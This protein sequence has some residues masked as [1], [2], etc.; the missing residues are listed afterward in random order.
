MAG[1]ELALLLTQRFKE[2]FSYL[3][4]LHV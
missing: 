4:K 2:L 3:K 1:N